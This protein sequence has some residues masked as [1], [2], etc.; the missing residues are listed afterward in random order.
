MS[1]I[2]PLEIRF[3]H[4]LAELGSFIDGGIAWYEAFLEEYNQR[5]GELLRDQKGATNEEV[6][7]KISEKGLAQPKQQQKKK[8]KGEKA[9]S[10][11][12][13]GWFTYK[14]LLFSA[15]KQGKAEILFEAVERIKKAVERLKETKSLAEELQKTGFD[16]DVSFSVYMIEGVPEK[17]FVEPAANS[18][19]KYSFEMI[20]SAEPD[21]IRVIK[22]PAEPTT[23]AEPQENP[24][25]A[26]VEEAKKDVQEAEEKSEPV[27]KKAGKGAKKVA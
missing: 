22:R 6:L 23:A 19:P 20:L 15:E 10:S 13:E 25:E 16:A 27:K 7:K 5:L 4:S 11:S 21:G 17:V 1:K 9:G 24:P 18:P 2:L 3:F 12:S 8:G 14:G 26:K